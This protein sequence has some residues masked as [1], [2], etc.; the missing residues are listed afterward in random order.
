M[1]GDHRKHQLQRGRLYRISCDCRRGKSKRV[2]KSR[3]IRTPNSSRRY[4][5]SMNRLI[6]GN[7][8]PSHI[9]SNS[10]QAIREPYEWTNPVER[11][12]IPQLKAMAGMKRWNPIRFTRRAAGACHCQHRFCKFATLVTYLNDNIQNVENRHS[13]LDRTPSVPDNHS[14]G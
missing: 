5:L 12:T 8:Q 13:G 4:Q 11:Q 10:R 1:R 6:L 3:K 2:P 14:V 7:R 9:P